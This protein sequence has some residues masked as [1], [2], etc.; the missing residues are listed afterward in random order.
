MLLQ[1]EKFQACVT[2]YS[3]SSPNID[4][5]G[6]N[7]YMETNVVFEV[8]DLKKFADLF[9]S[10]YTFPSDRCKW[11]ESIKAG[12]MLCSQNKG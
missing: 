12:I 3:A 9:E 11:Y 2:S 6:M 7:G 10:S 1:P 5:E 4:M 8:K